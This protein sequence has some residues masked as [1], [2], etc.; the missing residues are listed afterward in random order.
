ME[1]YNSENERIK[2]KYFVFLKEAKQYSE[3]SVD[4]AA[5]AISRFEEYGKHKNFKAF[6]FEQAVAFKKHLAKQ[7]NKT[8]DQLLSKS[9]LHSTL[10][11]LKK[12]AEWLSQQQGY[13]SRIQYSD[14]EYFNLSEKDTRIARAKR[15]KTFP[16]LEQVKH[17]LAVM[18]H[19][20]DIE[21]RNRALIAFGLLGFFPSLPF[22]SPFFIFSFSNN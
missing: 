22:F 5:K 21:Q 19:K 11:A 1:K 17:V 20:T 9:T 16:T 13:K 15:H 14:A 4:A 6:H 18:P 7:K 10:S 8:T 12:F 3:A 2:R